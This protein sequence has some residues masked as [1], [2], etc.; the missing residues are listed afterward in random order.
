MSRSFSVLVI[1][2]VVTCCS[3]LKLNQSSSTSLGVKVDDAPSSYAEQEAERYQRTLDLYCNMFE[4]SLL[5]NVSRVND[6]TDLEYSG[7]DEVTDLYRKIGLVDFHD[8][9]SIL[10]SSHADEYLLQRCTFKAGLKWER[11]VLACDNTSS[12]AGQ[13]Q[14]ILEL[15][16]QFFEFILLFSR[17]YIIVSWFEDRD[18]WYHN[19]NYEGSDFYS[20]IHTFFKRSDEIE[21]LEGTFD[22]SSHLDEYVQQRCTFKTGDGWRD[23]TVWGRY[24][25]APLD[26]QT[27]FQPEEQ[28]HNYYEEDEH[29]YYHF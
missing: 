20:Q 24:R 26:H 25:G 11:E 9:A 1:L 23:D 28:T 12:H 3:A 2:S 21:D 18:F 5:M 8:L 16:C 29:F 13:F 4:F 17:K 7:D 10:A 19:S 6:F 27:P 22:Y 14:R 15:Y